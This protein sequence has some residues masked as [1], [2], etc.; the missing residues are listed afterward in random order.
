MK[1]LT[2]KQKRVLDFIKEFIGVNK[3]P[4]TIREVAEKFQI[5]VKGG[6]DHIKALEKKKYLKCRVNRSRAIAVTFSDDEGGD[7]VSQ[8]PVLGNVAAGKPLFAAENFDGTI[9]VPAQ[10]LGKGRY[11]V[12]NV[13]GDSMQE[14]GIMDGDIAV[15]NYR[16]HADNGDIVVALIDEAVTLKRF[17]RQKNRVMLKAENS[18][19]AP[20]FSQDVKI[21]GK[22]VC[23]IRRYER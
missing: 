13:K 9:R 3:Y 15:I 5:S 19:Y 2:A 21:L 11:F 6:Y 7:R 23:L 16:N 20:I 4:P 10:F 12:L 18:A 14:A 1:G 17:F 22:L 8:L